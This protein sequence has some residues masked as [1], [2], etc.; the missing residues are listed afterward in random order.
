MK[1]LYL[2]R[3]A[4]SSWAD[5]SL[6]DFDRPLNERGKEAAFLMGKVM[7]QRHVSPANVVCSPAKR[8]RKTLKVA[9]ESAG[10][11]SQVNLEEGVYLASAEKLF[12]LLSNLDDSQESVMLIGHN[13]GLEDLVTGLT[14]RYERFPTATLTELE[15]D[16]DCWRA[17]RMGCGRIVWLVRPKE[18]KQIAGK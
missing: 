5:A 3:H 4:K 10:L 15:L 2:F 8:T 11:N 18:L 14:G 13:P 7:R 16:I 6:A 9:F 12:A 17:I 1:T